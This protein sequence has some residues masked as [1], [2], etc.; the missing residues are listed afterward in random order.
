MNNRD[1]ISLA[2]KFEGEFSGEMDSKD[3]VNNKQIPSDVALGRM[4]TLS[5][6]INVL[7]ER[8]ISHQEKM[9]GSF[10][11]LVLKYMTDAKRMLERTVMHARVP[12]KKYLW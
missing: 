10:P 3:W 9:H 5:H 6:E 1:L 8:I 12:N 4:K 11:V 7:C 2:N